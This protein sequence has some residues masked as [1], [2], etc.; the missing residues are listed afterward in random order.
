MMAVEFLV[1]SGSVSWS[2]LGPT[3]APLQAGGK[4]VNMLSQELT[5]K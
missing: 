4:E 3:P 1:G 2:Y 5:Y